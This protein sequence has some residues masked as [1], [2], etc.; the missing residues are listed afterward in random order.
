MAKT[1]KEVKADQFATFTKMGEHQVRLLLQAGK[2]SGT[3]LAWATEW[4]GKVEREAQLRNDASQEESLEIA[5]SAAAAAREAARYAKHANIIAIL[6]LI[7]AAVAIAL[8]F[9]PNLWG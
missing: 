3:K 5:R 8:P 1:F 4:L 2:Y 6:A 7:A 9:F